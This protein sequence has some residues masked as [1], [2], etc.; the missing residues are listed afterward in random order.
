MAASGLAGLPAVLLVPV[1]LLTLEP[2]LIAWPE[3][4][5]Q[6]WLVWLAIWSAVLNIIGVREVHSLSIGRSLLAVLSPYMALLVFSILLLA[7]LVM[8]AAALPSGVPLWNYF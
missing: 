7:A 8:A 3:T 6:G 5:S 2:V 1:Q 4:C